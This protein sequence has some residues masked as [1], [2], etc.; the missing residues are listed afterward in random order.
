MS[1]PKRLRRWPVESQACLPSRTTSVEMTMTLD[2]DS[3]VKSS[4]VTSWDPLLKFRRSTTFQS[5]LFRSVTQSLALSSWPLRQAKGERTVAC[6]HC[7]MGTSA[8]AVTEV[9]AD[10]TGAPQPQSLV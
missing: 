4:T 2:S 1:V 9:D 7:C 3:R 6:L 5:L 10:V 8:A